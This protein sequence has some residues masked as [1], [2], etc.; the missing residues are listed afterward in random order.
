[1]IAHL[2]AQYPQDRQRILAKEAEKIGIQ[3]DQDAWTWL[4]QHH[5]HNLLAAKKQSHARKR[6]LP[7]PSTD[8][9]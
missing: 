7:R 5:E 9:N 4:M 8:S 2:S 1:M 3:L 6:Y